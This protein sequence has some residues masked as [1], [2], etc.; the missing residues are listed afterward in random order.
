[1]VEKLIL[2][3]RDHRTHDWVQVGQLSYS[4]GKYYFEYTKEAK[5]LYG[6]EQFLP[7]SHMLNLDN[8][9]ESDELFPIFQNRL[10]HKSRPEYEDYLNWLK[11]SK[12]DLSPFMEL[13]RSGGMRATDDLQLFPYPEKR[14]GLYTVF[15][16]SHG[17]RYLPENSI[18]RINNLKTGDKLYI[19]PDI[20]NTVDSHAL[21]FRTE[22]PIEIVGYAPR[23]F[24]GEFTKLMAINGPDKVSVQVEQVNSKSPSQFRLLCKIQTIW[25]SDFKPFDSPLS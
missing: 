9:Y 20:Q 23:F 10:M 16:F 19:L 18:E 17:I 1:M 15:F 12:T 4:D 6:K 3:W 14:D 8:R 5:D 24:S 11:L 13:S 22:V 7:F 21:V 2:G 25:P